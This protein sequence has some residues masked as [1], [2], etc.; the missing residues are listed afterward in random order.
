ME[1]FRKK[2]TS[3]SYSDLS[4]F[5]YF[6]ETQAEDPTLLI[7]YQNLKD[8]YKSLRKPVDVTPFQEKKLIFK[9]INSYEIMGCPMLSLDL[10]NKYSETLLQ[11]EEEEEKRYHPKELVFT[12]ITMKL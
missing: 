10:I 11:T 9:A 8:N 4:G 5:E 2:V 7:L 12:E 1:N 3:N 6:H